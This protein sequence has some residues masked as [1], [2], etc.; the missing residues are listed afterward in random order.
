MYKIITALLLSTVISMGLV[1]CQKSGNAE[2]AGKGVDQAGLKVKQ[3][4]GDGGPTQ[5][6]GKKVDNAASKV[7]K[8]VTPNS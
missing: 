2:E 8:A 6:A 5:K 7:K 1:A 3:A 4:V